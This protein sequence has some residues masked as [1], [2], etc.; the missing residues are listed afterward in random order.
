M[1]RVFLF[2]AA[3]I[4]IVTASG[5]MSF[6][7]GVAGS[8]KPLAAGSYT[9]VGPAQGTA[10]GIMLIG[11][12]LSEPYPARSAVDRALKNGGGDALVNVTI[13]NTQLLLGPVTLVFTTAKGTA[14]KET[15]SGR[16]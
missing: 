2:I 3:L 16:R 12:P 8:T 10:F 9:E 5:C 1:K 4:L 11:I 6:P 13:D 7:A 15:S 14:V